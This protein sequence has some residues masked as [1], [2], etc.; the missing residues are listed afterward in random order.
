MSQGVLQKHPQTRI[1]LRKI[2]KK[3]Q[4]NRRHRD[5][6]PVLQVHFLNLLLETAFPIMST[7]PTTVSTG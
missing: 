3:I 4:Q 1:K 7:Y 2:A 6:W 5:C